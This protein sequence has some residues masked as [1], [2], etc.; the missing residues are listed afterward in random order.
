MQMK[1]C[2]QQVELII[3]TAVFIFL[4]PLSDTLRMHAEYKTELY[5]WSGVTQKIYAVGIF[6]ELE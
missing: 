3:A 1:I 2:Y 5:Y 4:L 6:K